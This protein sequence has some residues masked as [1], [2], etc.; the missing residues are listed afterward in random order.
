[1]FLGLT[2]S[3]DDIIRDRIVL[4]RERNLNVRLPYY[5]FA[6]TGTLALFAALQCALFVLIGNAIL[7]I[8]G[9]FWPHF[10]FNFITALGGI[11][12]GLFISSIVEDGKTAANIVPLILIPNI[13]L[14]GALIKYEDM[15]RDLDFIYRVQRFFST[16][17]R[18]AQDPEDTE[19]QVPLICE[20]IP[21]RWSYEA[22]VVA[23]G[24]L[25]P[26]TSRQ[27]RI[28]ALIDALVQVDPR[29][30]AQDDRL[31]DLKDTLAYLSGLESTSVKDI[32][33]RL[34]KIDKIIAGAPLDPAAVRSHRGPFSAERLFVNQKITDLVSKAET[35]QADYRRSE[36]VNVFFGPVKNI[37]AFQCSV[38][39]F[40]TS[41]LLGF[42][43]ICLGLLHISLKRQLSTK[44]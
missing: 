2:N 36:A 12:I 44:A 8:R 24:K 41:V 23:Q 10:L 3:C 5:I 43:A 1:M 25:N 39:L 32:E 4:Q 15:N 28:Q 42:T 11:A 34:R 14:G 35:D 18:V 31:D 7:E 22:L 13:I 29:S 17:P 40:N 20:F 16:H 6:K 33:D 27:D 21:M 37:G 26:L 30:P 9:M 38:L 19:V